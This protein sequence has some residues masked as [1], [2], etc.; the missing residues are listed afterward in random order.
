MLKD[1]GVVTWRSIPNR[2]NSHIQGWEVEV[3]KRRI[4]LIIRFQFDYILGQEQERR[5]RSDVGRIFGSELHLLIVEGRSYFH[6]EA[7]H[8]ALDERLGEGDT[9]KVLHVVE[10]L[11]D[12]QVGLQ[13]LDLGS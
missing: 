3:E 12:F 9:V 5:R 10:L 8:D 1:E 11:D 2:F 13:G 4:F 6:G 7:S